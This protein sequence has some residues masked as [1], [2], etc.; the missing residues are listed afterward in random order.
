[1]KKINLNIGENSYDIHVGTGLMQEVG[2]FMA[3]Y[4]LRQ[5]SVII[6]D[7]IVD[8]LYGDALEKSLT[9]RGLNTSRL[10]IP[11]GEKQKSLETA[12][13]LYTQMADNFA[14]RNTPVL[15]LGGG[16][17]G[18]LA[19]FVAA[20]YMRGVPLVQI[21][22]T[23]VA[24]AD[25]SIGGKTAVDH[26]SLKNM[27]GVFYQPRFTISDISVLKSLGERRFKEGLAEIIKHAIIQ[28]RPFFDYLEKN[29]EQIKALDEKT[30]EYVL[31]KSIEIKAGIVAKDESDLGVRRI[32]NFGHTVGHALETVS[33]FKI[34]HGEAVAI[35]MVAAAKVSRRR[36][37]LGSDELSRIIGLLESA[38]LPTGLPDLNIDAVVDAIRHDKKAVEGNIRFITILKL[39]DPVI[40]V[41]IGIKTLE[42]ILYNWNEQT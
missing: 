19:G 30:L 13:R 35:G 14:D 24:Q 36:A 37:M 25:S 2:R 5:K 21:P 34:S 4:D 16:V 31:A 6:T 41:D 23:L 28:D 7:T 29:M 10:V 20:T 27:I 42:D 40:S 1:M 11:A 3:S 39:G 8:K 9:D 38:G 18:D 15:A 12:G 32:L 17:I 22:T 33:D 26:G